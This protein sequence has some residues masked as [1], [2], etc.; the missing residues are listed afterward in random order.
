MRPLLYDLFASWH[1]CPRGRLPVPRH[2]E[3]YRLWH[4]HVRPW[5][6]VPASQKTEHGGCKGRA[7]GCARA[8]THTHTE[9]G[10]ERTLEQSCGIIRSSG[11]VS[12]RHSAALGSVDQVEQGGKKMGTW[13]WRGRGYAGLCRAVQGCAGLC[14]AVQSCAGL[15]RAV[16]GCAELCRAVQGCAGLCRAVQG[17]AGLCRA[18]QGCAGLCRAVQGCAGLCRAVRGCAGLCGAVQGC[19]GLCRAVQGCAGLC[20]AVQGCAGLCGAVQGCAGLCRAV[21]GCAGEP[22]ERKHVCAASRAARSRADPFVHL[23]TNRR[24]HWSMVA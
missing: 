17:C 22:P 11:V 18:V 1:L 8:H 4:M 3:R 14:G 12:R 2:V 10:R 6:G 20:R 13:D 19:A 5:R 7:R 23:Q 16:R 9:R 15:C 24:L 21:Q